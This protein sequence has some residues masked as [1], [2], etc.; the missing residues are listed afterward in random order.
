M[1]PIDINKTIA[2]NTLY[3]LDLKYIPFN[4]QSDFTNKTNDEVRGTTRFPIL[5]ENSGERTKDC[6]AI[7]VVCPYDLQVCTLVEQITCNKNTLFAINWCKSLLWMPSL[8][9]ILS[10]IQY[11]LPWSSKSRTKYL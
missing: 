9:D 10:V 1:T 7:I 2:L 3:I 5:K 11:S 4:Y 8:V 6:L